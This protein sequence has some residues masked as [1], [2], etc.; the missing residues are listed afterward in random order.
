MDFEGE[1][2]LRFLAVLAMTFIGL[3]SIWAGFGRAHWFVRVSVLLGWISLVLV[4][5]AYELLILFLVQAG[6][7]IAVLSAWR[8]WRSY[9]VSAQGGDELPSG[10]PIRSRWQFSV[11]DLLLLAVLV[12]WLSAM[13]ARVPVQV[14]TESWYWLL[15]GF[16]GGGLVP[17]GAWIALS[18]RRWWLR[19]LAACIFVPSALVVA[20]L[21][22]ARSAGLLR[23]R[24]SRARWQLWA[25]RASLTLVTLVIVL[26]VAAIYWRLATPLPIPQVTMPNP[27]GYDD[28]VQAGKMIQS[29]TVPY[30][31]P[32][33]FPDLKPATHAQLKAF[34]VTY[35]RL[36]DMMSAGLAKPCQVPVAWSDP[37]S[38][39]FCANVSDCQSFRELA[40]A[41]CA[42]ARLAELE[43]R[44][45]DAVGAHLE[46]IRLGEACSRGGLSFD[47]CVGD[48][49]VG[50]GHNGICRLRKSLSKRQCATL[51]PVLTDLMV[52]EGPL[53]ERLEREAAWNDNARGW[54]GRLLRAIMAIAGSDEEGVYRRIGLLATGK[55]QTLRE[56]LMQAR[57]RHLAE[58]RLLICDLAIRAY[59][60]DRGHNPAKLTELVPDYLPEAPKDP[61]SGGQLVYRITPNGYLLYSVGVNRVDDGG[62]P[63]DS[64]GLGEVGDILLDDPPSAPARP[65]ST[66]P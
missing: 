46:T 56:G 15:T 7:T 23:N 45:D 29:V 66:S 27:N 38:T 63:A 55:M 20:W 3:W 18:G 14:W 52:R 65:T 30:S 48:C 51:I 26:P 57:D 58:M 21:M 39:W 62:R 2:I 59:A 11:R 1:C 36:Y 43:G 25:S 44:I 37:Q 61:F 31:G 34:V 47:L 32:D 10:L 8:A 4:I 19:L 13:L 42:Q 17:A 28:L 9:R 12:A 41:L 64:A 53:E 5:P 60:L 22:L 16:I 33:I 50:I 6:V 40:H 35:A 54:M 24:A 49:I